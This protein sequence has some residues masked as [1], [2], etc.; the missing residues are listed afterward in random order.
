MQKV[1]NQDF[2]LYKKKIIV[3]KLISPSEISFK[4]I[5]EMTRYKPFGIGNTK[6][7]FMIQNLD[8][9]AIEYLGSGVDHI[10]INHKDG[11]KICGF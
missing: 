5:K 10:K 3:D 11:Y 7:I 8:Y 4:L 6:P 2:S 9:S 1:N